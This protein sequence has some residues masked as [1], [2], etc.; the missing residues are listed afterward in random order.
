MYAS[1]C[2]DRTEECN[3]VI[4]VR[5]LK[6]RKKQEELMEVQKHYS[7]SCNDYTGPLLNTIRSDYLDT[8][9]LFPVSYF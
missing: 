5:S 2:V 8:P 6:E 7:C 3:Y 4:G 9:P 1:I